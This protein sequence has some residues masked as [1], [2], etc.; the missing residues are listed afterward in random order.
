MEICFSVF[1][2]N[3]AS[4]TIS[5]LLLHGYLF[6]WWTKNWLLLCWGLG[7]FLP[8]LP[9]SFS[10][11]YPFSINFFWASPDGQS[12]RRKHINDKWAGKGRQ[13][14]IR[15]ALSG[16]LYEWSFLWPDCHLDFKVTELSSLTFRWHHNTYLQSESVFKPCS[17]WDKG[18]S[19]GQGLR[20]TGKTVLWR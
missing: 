19:S 3:H 18:I 7:F 17:I 2:S 5:T 9:L 12:Y 15:K 20:G 16:E 4:L 11:S 6:V 14:S 13:G 8:T 10:I 1:K